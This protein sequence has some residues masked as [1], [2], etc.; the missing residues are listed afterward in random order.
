MQQ[1]LLRSRDPSSNLIG[2]PVFSLCE[3]EKICQT[4][5]KKKHLHFRCANVRG[6]CGSIHRKLLFYSSASSRPKFV[7]FFRAQCGKAFS[8]HFILHRFFIYFYVL[9]LCPLLLFRAFELK[10]SRRNLKCFR[11]WMANILAKCIFLNY[12][13]P[14]L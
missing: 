1:Q 2:R 10:L 7:L 8:L 13:A 9:F 5:R 11:F 12:C 4:G 6:L 14:I 3:I